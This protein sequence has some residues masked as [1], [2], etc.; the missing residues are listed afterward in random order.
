MVTMVFNSLIRS[1]FQRVSIQRICAVH[2]DKKL[3]VTETW[4]KDLLQDYATQ[5]DCPDEYKLQM[6]AAL[7]YYPEL[8][9]TPIKVKYSNLETTATC[10]PA[11]PS[12]F[13]IRKSKSHARRKYI[14]RINKK[15][16]FSGVLM[17]DVPLNA[18]I[19]VLA[20]E[21]AHIVDYERRSHVGLLKR[22]LDYLEENRKKR[23]EYQ[24]D[25][26]TIEHGL[27]WQLY[28][29]A[30]YAMHKSKASEKY[31]A[32]KK[33][34]YMGPADIEMHIQSLAVQG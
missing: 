10:R 3:D 33:R 9:N 29:W 22:A 26:L 8:R 28:D 27:G 1:L 18:Q 23:F 24:I 20:H 14:I 6:L 7:S 5:L 32:F 21:I 15:E 4:Q 30:D 25:K 16:N 17:K 12:I 13:T 34:I 11:I 2:A 31:K 19:G